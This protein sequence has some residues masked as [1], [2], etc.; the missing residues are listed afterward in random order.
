MALTNIEYGSVA[1]SEVVNNNFQYLD[2][3][4]ASVSQ[5]LSAN[6]TSLS[7]SI[8]SLSATVASNKNDVDGKVSTLQQDLDKAESDLNSCMNRIYVKS[9][10]RSGKNWY[11]LYSDSWIEQGGY[12]AFAQTDVTKNVSLLKEMR[13]VNASVYVSPIRSHTNGDWDIGIAGGTFVDTKTIKITTGRDGAC[14]GVY[15]RVSG[16]AK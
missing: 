8:S 16:F 6:T 14:G 15:W 4:I 12:I 3:K 9:S 13:D 5:S 10:Y 7:G 2:D 1:S 11:R